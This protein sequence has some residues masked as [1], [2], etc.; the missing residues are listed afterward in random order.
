MTRWR[1]VAVGAPVLVALLLVLA[2]CGTP[3]GRAAPGPV[4][5]EATLNVYRS[6]PA[7]WVAADVSAVMGRASLVRLQEVESRT[8]RAGVRLALARHPGWVIVPGLSDTGLRILYD[9]RV[10]ARVGPG[11]LHRVQPN[12]RCCG[13][14]RWWVWVT[15]E[16]RATGRVVTIVNIHAVAGYCRAPGLGRRDV[17]AARY[18]LVFAAW[19][20]QQ[21]IR[22][23]TRPVLAGGDFN[24][25][26]G[27]RDAPWNP[28][29]VL[30]ALYALDRAPGVD[31]LVTSRV[32][33]PPM[34]LHRWSAP[35]HS[36]HDAQYRRL[37]LG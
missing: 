15:L 8:A 6:N 13:P 19:S 1:L 22:H 5:T 3:T 7:R 17:W 18:W 37:T 28:G 35:A 34:T 2:V 23:P 20:L 21:Q 27:D 30:G 14:A 9:T 31:R 24:C 32:Q 36:D 26:L 25:G 4:V 29:P 11:R 16:H 10:W 12:T 33:D